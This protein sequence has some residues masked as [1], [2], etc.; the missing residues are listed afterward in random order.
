ML[1]GANRNK[2]KHFGEPT[3]AV[4]NCDDLVYLPLTR[5]QQACI[6]GIEKYKI[7]VGY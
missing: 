4:C 6:N 3:S 5:Q 2:S 7:F 1:A